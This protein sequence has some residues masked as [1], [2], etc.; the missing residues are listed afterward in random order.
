[1]AKFF[2]SV[3]LL[4]IS[5][6]AWGQSTYVKA[7]V[8]TPEGYVGECD[9]EFKHTDSSNFIFATTSP[10]ANLAEFSHA[11]GGCISTSNGKF[12]YRWWYT[13]AYYDGYNKV[14]NYFLVIF[15]AAS[16]G[17]CNIFFKT[18]PPDKSSMSDSKY[19]YVISEKDWDTVFKNFIVPSTYNLEVVSQGDIFGDGV[20]F[21]GHVNK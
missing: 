18:C 11:N 17:A 14:K 12:G 9:M 7:D 3:V 10:F 21:N 1:M 19:M 6:I 5:N 16:N 2:I 4:F 15:D 20:H 8:Y 13:G